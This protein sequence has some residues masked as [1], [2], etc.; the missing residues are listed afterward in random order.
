MNLSEKMTAEKFDDPKVR[1]LL[2][3]MSSDAISGRY[4]EPTV[5]TVYSRSLPPEK[6]SLASDDPAVVQAMG[7]CAVSRT[8]SDALPRLGSLH[9]D[10]C[11]WCAYPVAELVAACE[12]GEWASRYI[13]AEVLTWRGDR[14]SYEREGQPARY[15]NPAWRDF[16]ALPISDRER[17]IEEAT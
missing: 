12:W 5:H 17:R 10:E 7:R 8:R 4:G 15:G 13:V 11:A 6:P 2:A 14:S 1:E 3:E 9:G 16:W